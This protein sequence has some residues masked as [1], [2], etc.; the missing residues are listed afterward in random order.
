MEPGDLV[1]CKLDEGNYAGK[2]VARDHLT[3][4]ELRNKVLSG[5]VCIILE[6]EDKNHSSE[7]H[8]IKILD[9]QGKVDWAFSHHF[10]KVAT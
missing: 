2:L 6:T 8:R 1:I 7:I 10:F 4:S 3:W 5:E 9:S